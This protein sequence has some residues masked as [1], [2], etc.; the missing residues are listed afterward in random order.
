MA[1]GAPFGDPNGVYTAGYVKLYEKS[2]SEWDIMQQINGTVTEGKFGYSV[3]LSNDASILT[4]VSYHVAVH[5]FEYSTESKQYE[6]IDTKEYYAGEVAVSPDG[7]VVGIAAGNSSSEEPNYSG[8]RIFERSGTG[9]QQ[10]GGDFSEYGRFY[11]G[12]DLNYD[13]SVVIIGDRA[14]SSGRG[15]VGVFQ[16][17]ENGESMDWVQ[18]GNDFVGDAD[19]DWMGYLGCVSITHDGMTVTVGAYK[20]DG[21][22][23][24]VR[25]YDYDESEEMWNKFGGDLTGDYSDDYF[26]ANV[27]SADG[28]Y[29]VVG[30]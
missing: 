22:K 29:L 5:M 15:R 4:I 12:I 10:R 18:M 17:K 1:V 28:M 8:A 16:W 13:G 9:F 23:G 2:G 6:L 21:T 14:W 11:S 3:A 25:V 19:G 27:L 26:S 24:L 30:A 7:M 20:Y